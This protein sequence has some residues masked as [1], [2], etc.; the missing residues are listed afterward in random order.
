[1]VELISLDHELYE[2]LNAFPCLKDV[3]ESI[4]V[5]LSKLSEGVTLN[6]YLVEIGYNKDEI[7]LLVS[8][9]NSEVNYFLK[10]GESHASNSPKK[11]DNKENLGI[12]MII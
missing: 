1:M 9:M 10:T 11:S 2:V 8:K 12:E 4:N 3:L 5:D 7:Q 6:S